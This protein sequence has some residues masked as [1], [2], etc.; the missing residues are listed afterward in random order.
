MHSCASSIA[1]AEFS[2][3]ETVQR[4]HTPFGQDFSQRKPGFFFWLLH[5]LSPE[6]PLFS[7][8]TK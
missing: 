2:P 4:L 5:R 7:V 1:A 3:G 8:L 6:P